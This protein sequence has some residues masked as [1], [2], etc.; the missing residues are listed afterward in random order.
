LTDG[1]VFE[2]DDVSVKLIGEVAAYTPRSIGDKWYDET[3][4]SNHGT[5]TGATAVNRPTNHQGQ[6]VDHL[7]PLIIDEG[8]TGADRSLLKLNFDVSVQDKYAQIE[9]NNTDD[10]ANPS[11]E[12]AFLRC[13]GIGDYGSSLGLYTRPTGNASTAT[14]ERFHVNGSGS[15]TATSGTS[16][17]LKQVARVHSQNITFNSTESAIAFRVLHNLGTKYVTV[18]VCENANSGGQLAAHVET[19]VR[20]GDCVGADIGAVTTQQSSTDTNYVTIIFSGHQGNNTAF[21]VTVIG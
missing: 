1:D 9:F 7:G 6:V 16:G 3:S 11:E 18:S 13:T 17:N 4:N 10:T 20:L 14:E 5:I 21:K 15:V 8:D 2:L 12:L 19:E